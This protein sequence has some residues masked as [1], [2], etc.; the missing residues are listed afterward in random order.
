MPST[1]RWPSALGPAPM[2]R[3]TGVAPRTPTSASSAKVTVRTAPPASDHVRGVDDRALAGVVDQR[4]L[5]V[6]R[7]RRDDALDQVLL[8]QPVQGQAEAAAEDLAALLD[9]R[10]ERLVDVVLAREGRVAGGRE[11]TGGHAVHRAGAVEV[12]GGLE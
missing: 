7:V 10:L 4:V 2:P 6:Q 8:A 3:R 11:A 1:T 12:D 5:H 9:E